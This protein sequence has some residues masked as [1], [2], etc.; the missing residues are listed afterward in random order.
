MS[1]RGDCFSTP[2]ASAAEGLFD[3]TASRRAD[4]AFTGRVW[5]VGCVVVSINAFLEGENGR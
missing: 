1:A 3:W 5:V 4:K 2:G